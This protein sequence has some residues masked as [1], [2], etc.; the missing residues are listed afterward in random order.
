M[1]DLPIQIRPMV[2]NDYDYVIGFWLQEFRNT[3]IVT[4]MSNNDYF[5]W[6]KARINHCIANTLI[7]IAHIEDQPDDIVG[8]ICASK[9]SEDELLVH[10]ISVKSAFRRFGVAKKLIE[11]YQPFN[12]ILF[13]HYFKLFYQLK[14]KVNLSYKPLLLEIK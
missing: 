9:V 4:L 14:D 3:P 1:N 6:Q 13:T 5:P 12:K 11:Q 8:F 2:S 10:W 7:L